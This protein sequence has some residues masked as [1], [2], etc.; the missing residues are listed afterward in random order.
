MAGDCPLHRLGEI[1]EQVPPV[2][3][4]DGERR[5]AGRALGIAAARSRQIT[6]TP[7]GCPAT[8]RGLRGSPRQHVDRPAG[9]DVD[10]D[11]AVDMPAAQREV[12]HAQDP[13]SGIGQGPDQQQ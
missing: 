9:L 3:D 11:G 4:L 7:A 2:R 5:A 8:T 6:S 10:Q 13:R 12:I 1:M